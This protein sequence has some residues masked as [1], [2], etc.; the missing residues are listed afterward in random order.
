MIEQPTY[1]RMNQ[2][3]DSQQL[4]YRTIQRNLT[5]LISR[6]LKRFSK[7][8][9]S[10]SS[11]R[12][13]V[14]TIRLV[15]IRSSRKKDLTTKLTNIDVYLVEDDYLGDLDSTMLHLFIIWIKRT[16]SSISNLFDQSFSALRITSHDSSQDLLK[17]VLT[18]KTILNYDSNLIM[19]KALSLY[20]D[21][22]MHLT[23]KSDS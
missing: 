8:V 16:E 9:I 12:S 11:T 18:Y 2:L 21:N 14:F 10:N 20:I 23:N 6:N 1:H 19:Q 5:G 13:L 22:G 15:F 3:F 4:A 17:P 7:V